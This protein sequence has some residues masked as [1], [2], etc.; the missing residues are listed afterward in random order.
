MDPELVRCVADH[1]ELQGLPT[2]PA[3]GWRRAR[4]VTGL[5]LLERYHGG[6]LGDGQAARGRRPRLLRAAGAG[7]LHQPAAAQLGQLPALQRPH[8]G[9]RA[10]PRLHS[11]AVRLR[12]ML[13]LLLLLLL[14]QL[15][16]CCPLP[17]IPVP[18]IL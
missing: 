18:A 2:F 9:V 16:R 6:R 1:L 13:L 5:V 14:L 4:L 11:P 17:V 15:C 8:V 3:A 10:L 12:M 7:A